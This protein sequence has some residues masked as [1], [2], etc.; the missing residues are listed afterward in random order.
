MRYE[1]RVTLGR[2]ELRAEGDAKSI[3]GYAAVFN[4]ETVVAGLF[5]ERIAPGAFRSATE[6]SA[7]VVSL[8][9]HDINFVLGRTTAGTLAVRQDETG[10]AYDTTPPAS[11]ADVIESVERGDVRGSSFTFR[12]PKGGDTW[13]RAQPGELPLRTITQCEIRDVGPV[14]F[15]AYEATTAEARSAAQAVLTAAG[16][17]IEQRA[18]ATGL[19]PD[20]AEEVAELVSYTAMRRML[21]SFSAL[22]AQTT[23]TVDA[24]IADE[25]EDPT[26]TADEEA[27]EE[28]MESARLAVIAATTQQMCG[29]L[30]GVQSLVYRCQRDHEKEDVQ[31][32]VTIIRARAELDLLEVA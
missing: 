13:T 2:V 25:T 27:A 12:V 18:T 7:D 14:T 22:L 4:T 19:T 24:L 10:L 11:R 32:D 17:P 29:V 5:R 9:N 23:E 8:F 26:A 3:H 20:A 30:Y 15:P 21:D 31:V 1:K 6:A 16:L 28:D